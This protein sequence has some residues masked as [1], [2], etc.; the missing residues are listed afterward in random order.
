MVGCWSPSANCGS[1]GHSWVTVGPGCCWGGLYTP[2]YFPYGFHSSMN[3]PYGFHGLVHVDSTGIS[4]GLALQIHVPFHKDS[5]EE[6]QM[7]SM[8]FCGRTAM[9]LLS[10]I[11]QML[12]I[13]H[14]PPQ[15]VTWVNKEAF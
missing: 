12:R 5:M 1:G 8:E 3:I 7:D 11:M 15:H 4:N 9:N 6:V 13:E 10:N 2:Q 14:L